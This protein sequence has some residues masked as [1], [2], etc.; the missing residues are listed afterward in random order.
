MAY[1]NFIKTNEGIWPIE[2]EVELFKNLTPATYVVNVRHSQSGPYITLT[3]SKFNSDEILDIPSE[4]Y[5]IVTSQMKKFLKPE[6]K[7][8]FKKLGYL[9]KRST[10]LHGLP[11]TGKTCITSR[12][13]KDVVESG[14]VVFLIRN[15]AAFATL[16]IVTAM[17]D[18]SPDTTILV[19]I[20]EI[21]SALS[22]EGETMF[23][24]LLDGQV[25]RPNT[26]YLATT[27]YID[28]VPARILRP[29]RMSSVIEVK[30]PD[31]K[32]RKYYL[33]HK[34]GKNFDL[35]LLKKSDG[36]SID[37][38]KEL[39]L[40]TQILGQDVNNTVTRLL[41]TQQELPKENNE[42]E[43]EN[44]FNPWFRLQNRR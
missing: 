8:L 35:D 17:L 25:Q 28:R 26:M 31:E 16:A 11:G 22:K 19:I 24:N 6:T 2:G 13:S 30:Y 1:T 32:A 3:E 40:A 5:E 36:L 18:I 43:D 41:A 7:K 27:N 23:L 20:E 37:S 12:V 44:D 42:S 4:E 21:D 14:G 9:Y 15:E 38:L 39:I 10:L 29:G 33:E 34:L